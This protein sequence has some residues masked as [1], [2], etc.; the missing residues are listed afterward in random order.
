MDFLPAFLLLPLYGIAGGCGGV[1]LIGSGVVPR[2]VIKQAHENDGRGEGQEEGKR[3]RGFPAPC[4]ALR[5][6]AFALFYFH[7]FTIGESLILVC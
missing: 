1:I 6:F 3:S 5:L 2:L 4:R 7:Y